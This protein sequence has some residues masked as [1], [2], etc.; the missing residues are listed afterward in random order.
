[1]S[2]ALE[3]HLIALA[4]AGDPAAAPMIVSYLADRLLGYAHGLAPHLYDSDREQ[5]VELAVEAGLRSFDQFDADRGSLFSWF[6]RQVSYRTADWNRSAPVV[7]AVDDDSPEPALPDTHADISRFDT[8]VVRDRLAAAIQTLSTDD[9]LILALRGSEQL[10]F[11]EIAMRLDIP[12]PTARQRFRRARLRLAPR[13]LA[14]DVLGPL[15]QVDTEEAEGEP[16]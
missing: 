8:P 1:M 5:I 6:R 2:D 10:T 11:G 15:I 3:D 7:V 4:R 12:E 14:D 13:I 16:T 9:R